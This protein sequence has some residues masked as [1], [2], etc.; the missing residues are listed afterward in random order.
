[1]TSFELAQARLRNQRISGDPLDG[2]G[3][4]AQW[5]VAVQAQDYA[6]AQWALGLRMPPGANAGEV[7]RALADGTILRTHV[8]RPTWHF[9]APDDIRWLLAPTAPRVHAVNGTL[10]R[11][12]GLDAATLARGHRA[13]AAALEGGRQLTRDELRDALERDGIATDG[14]RLAYILMSAELEGLICSGA[15]R[16]KQFTYALLDSRA[17][18]ARIL[19][20]EDALAE[21]AGRYFRSRGPATVHDLAKWSGL[22]VAD[23]RRGLE[24]VEAQFERETIGGQT[25]WFPPSRGDATS[26][27]PSAHLLSIYD[28]YVSSYKDRSA[29]ADDDT[30]GRLLAMG[31]AL[32]FIIVI[33]GRVVGAWRRTLRR[34]AVII[35]VD[36]FRPLAEDEQMA[37]A[38]AADRYA[39][40]VDLPAEV[41]VWRREVPAP[42][43]DAEQE[44]LA[45]SEGG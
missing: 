28:E 1:V 40:F 23:A 36:L 10:Y 3:D 2:P 39:A 32:R 7:D 35:E 42:E 38:L 24:A 18:G 45:P 14:L 43:T 8:L 22:T 25:Y 37:V 34:D 27:S 6:G 30:G 21:L 15:R 11:H 4:V 29:M 44:G 31:N 12:Q 17:P 13:L 41:D 33:D 16:G 20:R 5:L 9:V 19:A 26:L